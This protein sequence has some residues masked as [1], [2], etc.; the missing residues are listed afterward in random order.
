MKTG[1][2]TFFII[3]VMSL[4]FA[5][6]VPDEPETKQK[7]DVKETIKTSIKY[8]K[9]AQDAVIEG[10]VYVRLSIQKDGTIKIMK[11]ASI[12]EE[13]KDYVKEELKKLKLNPKP[14]DIDKPVDMKFKFELM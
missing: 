8:P 1:I 13:L 3:S 11:I 12:E 9:F 10:V 14:E 7:Q 4:S 2:V 5:F 6:A